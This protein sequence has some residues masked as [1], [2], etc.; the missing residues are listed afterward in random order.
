MGVTRE[1]LQTE[2]SNNL[3]GYLLL[4]GLLALGVDQGLRAFQNGGRRRRSGSESN[5]KKSAP[6]PAG[7]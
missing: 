5:N 7:I 4:A 1:T 3:T 6:T 2:G